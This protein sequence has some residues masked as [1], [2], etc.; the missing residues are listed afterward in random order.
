MNQWLQSPV[1]TT[2]DT[3]A[4]HLSSRAITRYCLLWHVTIAGLPRCPV[5]CQLV[6]V[7]TDP[8]T[9]FT[10]STGPFLYEWAKCQPRNTQNSG[11]VFPIVNLMADSESGSPFLFKFHSNHRSISLSFGDIHVWQTDRQMDNADHYYSWYPHCG[12]PAN[13]HYKSNDKNTEA[14]NRKVVHLADLPLRTLLCADLTSEQSCRISICS[15]FRSVQLKQQTRT[16]RVQVTFRTLG[17]TG[18]E[19][20]AWLFNLSGKPNNLRPD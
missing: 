9:T 19:L 17:W 15:F 12:G 13:K 3:V 20:R 16:C 1:D 8:F 5:W 2:L 4:G 10:R 18:I 11:T 14:N 7:T 6:T